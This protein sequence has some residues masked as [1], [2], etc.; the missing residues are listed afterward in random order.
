MF[1]IEICQSSHYDASAIPVPQNLGRPFVKYLARKEE[2]SPAYKSLTSFASQYL[3][4]LYFKC[5]KVSVRSPRITKTNLQIALLKASVRS[6][7]IG[8]L[9]A[10][11]PTA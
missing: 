4:D 8:L 5:P 1:R 3:G 11:D 9:Y 10:C 2:A 7:V 6:S